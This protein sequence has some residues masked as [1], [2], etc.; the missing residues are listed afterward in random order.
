MRWYVV[1]ARGNHAS[2]GAKS[3]DLRRHVSS[4]TRIQK[5]RVMYQAKRAPKSDSHAIPMPPT[6]Q[7]GNKG[8]GSRTVIGRGP[9]PPPLLVVGAMWTGWSLA[10]P[11]VHVPAP[12]ATRPSFPNPVSTHDVS[13]GARR[14]CDTPDALCSGRCTAGAG[15]VGVGVVVGARCGAAHSIPYTLMQR[16]AEN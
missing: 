9:T 6:S 7:S 13:D 8:T 16:R 5:P 15:A 14:A 2:V 10:I 1:F 12:P 3:N 11:A 4:S